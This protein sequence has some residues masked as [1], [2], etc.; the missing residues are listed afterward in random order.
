MA[1]DICEQQKILLTLPEHSKDPSV[2]SLWSF[3]LLQL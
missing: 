3:V 2:R 1:V